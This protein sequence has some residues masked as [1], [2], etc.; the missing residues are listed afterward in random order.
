MILIH[1][2]CISD[3]DAD[4]DTVVTVPKMCPILYCILISRMTNAHDT[5]I[6]ASYNKTTN[7]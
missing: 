3:T 4:T 2:T 6:K 5:V 1:P 7:A